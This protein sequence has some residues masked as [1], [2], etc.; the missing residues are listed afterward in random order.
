MGA[1]SAALRWLAIPW[2]SLVLASAVVGAF[3]VPTLM[4]ASADMFRVSAADEITTTLLDETDDRTGVTVLV[5]GRLT[6]EGVDGLDAAVRQALGRVGG[7]GESDRVLGTEA[8]GLDLDPPPAGSREPL[9]IEPGSGARLFARAGAVEALDVVDGPVEPAARVEVGGLWVSERLAERLGL[10]VGDTVGL[11]GAADRVEIAG[12]HRGVW[13]EPRDPYWD[14]VPPELVPSWSPVLHGPLFEIFVATPQTATALGI[15]GTIRWDAALERPPTSRDELDALAAS[16]RRVERSFTESGGMRDA[17]VPVIGEG[18]PLPVLGTDL[19]DL[20]DEME[21]R[22]DELDQ[23]ISMTTFAGVMLGLAVAATGA[24]FTAR[25]RRRELRLLRADG[26]AAWRFAARA[27]AQYAAPAG[28]GSALGVLAAWAV[29]AVAGPTGAAPLDAVDVSQLVVVT[30]VALALTGVATAAVAT[31]ALHDEPLRGGGLPLAGILFALGLGTAAWI[32]VGAGDR[33]GEVDALVVLFPFIG[34]VGGIALVVTLARWAVR[35]ARGAGS[36]L[37]PAGF[38]AWRR[39]AAADAGATG[40]AT[41]MGV[42]L[43]LAVFSTLLIGSFES[44]ASAK[45]V[46]VVGGESS[47]RLNGPLPDVPHDS[48]VVRTERTRLSV[49]D[50]TVA[51]LAVDPDTFPDGVSWHSRFGSSP[52][53]VIE[54]LERPVDADVAVVVAGGRPVAPSGAFGTDDVVSYQVVDEIDS[55]PLATVAAPTVLVS[56]DA[57]E[58]VGRARHAAWR[59]DDVDEDAWAE[60][61]VPLVERYG[62]TVVSQLPAADLAE[63]LEQRGVPF[64]DLVTAADERRSLDDRAARWTFV[65]LRLLALVGALSA[66]GALAFYLSE[67]QAARELAAVVLDRM[68]FRRRSSVLSAVLEVLG[69]AAVAFAAAGVVAVALAGRVFARFEPDPTIPPEAALRP[70]ALAIA[71]VGAGA[72]IAVAVVALVVQLAAGRRDLDEVLR[73]R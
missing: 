29:I 37:P 27:V 15:G 62:R 11:E 49:G 33:R 48:T 69:L 7:L 26:D 68:G 13:E 57:L 66:L 56:V 39:I 35:R 6:P 47:A 60:G 30:L 4:M 73:E 2:R 38:L 64:G 36:V 3:A 31:R 12:I 40:L 72:A 18:G 55:A 44:A 50:R 14:D 28:L 58:E 23:P 24:A 32:Q 10:A 51:V 22:V 67:Q 17:L 53:Q 70:S 1:V 45:T 43:G 16:T 42:T 25:K 71:G 59:P 41:V 21:R 61:Y 63:L 5:Q 46:T 54:A 8:L 52:T 19:F 65:H 20:R 34:L 9:E